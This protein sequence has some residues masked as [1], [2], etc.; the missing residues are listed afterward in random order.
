MGYGTRSVGLD[1]V[2]QGRLYTNESYQ[3]DGDWRARDEVCVCV[4]FGGGGMGVCGC[5][6]VYVCGCV[7]VCMCMFVCFAQMSPT[8]RRVT[9]FRV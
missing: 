4:C 8:C 9:G 3:P 6:W 5:V 2:A 7:C 1:E